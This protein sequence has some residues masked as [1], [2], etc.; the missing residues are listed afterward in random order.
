MASESVDDVVSTE[1]SVANTGG[2]QTSL[3]L[4]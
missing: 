2:G 4:E 3:P 1:T